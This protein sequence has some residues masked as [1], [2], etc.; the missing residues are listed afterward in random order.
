MPLRW[1]RA[2]LTDLARHHQFLTSVNE[3]GAG[4]ALQA[5]T[6]APERLLQNHRV[7]ER[8]EEF[9]PREVRRILVGPYE[10]RYEVADNATYVLRLWYTREER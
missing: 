7:G 8:L 2:A 9:S 10:I 3:P 4:R 6:A 5:L 1:T